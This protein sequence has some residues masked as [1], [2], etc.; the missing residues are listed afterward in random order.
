MD[1]SKKK[2]DRF[3]FLNRIYEVS[4]GRT[5]YM[6]NG[7]TIGK[8][9]GFDR[10]YSTAIYYYLNDEGLTEPMGSG[11][12]LSLTHYGIKQ[13]EEALSE[14]NEPTEYFPPMNIINIG[15][16]Q[17]GVVQ[18]G[19]GN[20]NINITSN[21]TINNLNQYLDKLNKFA[22]KYLKNDS[23]QQEIRADVNTIKQQLKSPKPK[24][25]IIKASI[26]SV[27]EILI[28]ASGGL[29]GSLAL[30]EVQN[31]IQTAEIL[32]SQVSM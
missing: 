11:I 1:I 6:I 23:L 8:E 25:T 15:K 4:D 21:E 17:G 14:P 32:I 26:Q 2:Q 9:F 3:K 20:S 27:K 28:G 18:Q 30:P 19:T 31:L 7:E 16:M 13:I 10:G 12:Y 29:I 24:K 22:D 5:G